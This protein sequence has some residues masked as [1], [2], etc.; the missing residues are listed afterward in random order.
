MTKIFRLFTATVLS[1]ML[2]S[3]HSIAG[4]PQGPET[5]LE[6]IPEIRQ[7]PKKESVAAYAEKVDDPIND[8]QFSVKLFETGKTFKYRVEMQYEEVLGAD[9]IRLPD[10]GAQ[11]QPELRKGSEKYSCVIGFL[12]NGN[13]FREYKLVS[14]TNGKNLSI[15]TLKHF[16]VY[17]REER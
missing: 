6:S 7:T 5:G 1:Y 4:D 13:H 10:F 8:W 3:C 14:V 12:D 17:V 16:R 9:T 2:C 15:T 11:P